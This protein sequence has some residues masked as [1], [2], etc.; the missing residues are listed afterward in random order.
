VVAQKSLE[1][2]FSPLSPIASRDMDQ[3]CSGYVRP[4][5]L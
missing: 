4:S 3:G 5:A 2:D 1:T